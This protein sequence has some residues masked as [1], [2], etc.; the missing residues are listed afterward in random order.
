[1][2]LPPHRQ[3]V[4]NFL[5]THGMVQIGMDRQL[6]LRDGFIV[7]TVRAEVDGKLL[8]WVPCEVFR[9]ADTATKWFLG[10]HA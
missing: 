7:G 1:M 10:R 2:S 8:A 4:W 3:A 5:Q 6:V 9:D